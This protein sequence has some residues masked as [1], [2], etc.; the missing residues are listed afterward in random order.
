MWTLYIEN[1]GNFPATNLIIDLEIVIKKATWDTGIDDIDIKN[2]K[3][4]DFKKK[5]NR[6]KLIIVQRYL[7][8]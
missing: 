6:L 2:E 4:E 1:K 5:K 7:V 3:F 8:K